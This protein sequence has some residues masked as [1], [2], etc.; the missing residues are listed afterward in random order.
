MSVTLNS[1]CFFGEIKYATKENGNYNATLE[2]YVWV[3]RELLPFVRTLAMI[4]NSNPYA[5]I[6]DKANIVAMNLRGES[7]VLY[8]S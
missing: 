3:L 7:F 2:H 5:Y 1:A 8:I 4:S 6:L